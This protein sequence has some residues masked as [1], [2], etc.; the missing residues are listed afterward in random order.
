[1][2][3][4]ANKALLSDKFSVAL[5]ICRRARRYTP[6]VNADGEMRIDFADQKL[7]GKRHISF[8]ERI[9]RSSTRYIVVVGMLLYILPVVVISLIEALFLC[10]G[11]PLVYC[12]EQPAS[13]LELLYFNF[14]TIITIGYGD[15]HPVSWGRLFSVIEGIIGVGVF[16]LLV[17]AIST[18]LFVTS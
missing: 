1:M 2:K 7:P 10:S 18:K 9:S 6:I 4:D 12:K 5:Q 16:G 15:L 8:V 11:N 3:I 13:L 17:A 14:V